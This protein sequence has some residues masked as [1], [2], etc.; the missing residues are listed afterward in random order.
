MPLSQPL[1]SESFLYVAAAVYLCEESPRF[2][3]FPEELRGRGCMRLSIGGNQVYDQDLCFDD[4]AA[5][6]GQMG[7]SPQDKDSFVAVGSRNHHGC[8]II[9]YRGMVQVITQWTPHFCG[10]VI[11]EF[12][13]HYPISSWARQHKFVHDL[14]DR[15]GDRWRD[16]VCLCEMTANDHDEP[17]LNGL[18][19]ACLLPCL[20]LLFPP[21]QPLRPEWLF[22]TELEPAP[23]PLPFIQGLPRGS[24]ILK[25]SLGNEYDWDQERSRFQH[26]VTLMPLLIQHHEPLRA[27]I[28]AHLTSQFEAGLNGLNGPNA[29][30]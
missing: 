28:R 13:C 8:L 16:I 27:T 9:C 6:D 23:E 17:E 2:L 3:P 21:G 10:E 19:T 29:I 4:F 24:I 22:V 15:L 14:I 1:N 7:S 18:I 5:W 20:P 26:F 11:L 25:D 12:E 30:V